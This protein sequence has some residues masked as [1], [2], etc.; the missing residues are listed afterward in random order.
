MKHARLLLPNFPASVLLALMLCLACCHAASAQQFRVKKFSTLT[1]DINA[2]IKPVYDL[3]GEACAVVRVVAPSDFVFSTPLGI[4][5]RID[6]VGEILIYLPRGSKKITIKHPEWGV[7]RDYMFPKPLESRL[8]YEMDL[9][10]PADSQ[11]VRHDTITLTRTITR[12]D[13]VIVKKPARLSL[14]ILPL[15]TLS[16]HDN[17]PSYGLMVAVMHRHGIYLHGQ[18]DFHTIGSTTG[19]VNRDG[20]FGG[21]GVKPFYTGTTRHSA[22]SVTGGLIH[23][24]TRWLNVFYGAG[25]GSYTTAWQLGAA[26]GGGYVVNDGLSGNGIAG[27]AGA[28]VTAGRLV[29][30]VSALTVTGKRW[31]AGFGIGINI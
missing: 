2:F 18:T 1:Y 7:L 5:K 20:Y 16:L 21:N 27:E 10:T 14:N 8:T 6:E 30:S 23:R 17:G 29:L 24:I 12:T 13:T 19:T 11:E 4:V 9:A 15:L 28:A 31:Q 26:E 25:Y 22:W 3:N